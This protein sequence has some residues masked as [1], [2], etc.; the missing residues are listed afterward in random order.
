MIHPTYRRLD[1]PP[2]LAG[3]SFLQWVALLVLA[4]AV[5]GL[6]RVLSL[7]TQPAIS[8]FTLLVGGPAALM[9]FSE[10]GRP[11]LMRLV[12]EG[13]RWLRSPRTY[14]PGGGRGR[15]LEIRQPAADRRR[16]G[17]PLDEGER[18]GEG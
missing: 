5:Y 6:E 1:E 16:R 17:G 14:T 8:A 13:A 2:K 4:A 18:G 7:P 9:Y 3:F 10:S 15:A 12:R 11:S